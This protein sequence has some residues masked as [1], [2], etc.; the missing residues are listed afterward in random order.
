MENRYRNMSKLGVRNIEGYN[1]RIKEAVKKGEVLMRKIQTGFDAETGKPVYE[2]QPL[3]LTELP[4]IV[5]VVDEFA[6]LMLVAGK[7]VE[8]AIQ[9]L[10]QMARAAGIHLIMA[11]Q[12]PSVDVITGVIKA[13]FPTR[14]SFQVTSKIDSRTILGEGGAETLL[15][16]GD[17]LYM[18]AG[19]RITRVH[20]PFVADKEVEEV[21]N[22]LKTQ[23]EPSYL[24]DITEGDLF[25]DGGED[26][27][28]GEACDELYDEAVAIVA[29]EGKASTS[30][31]QRHLQI[32]Y[33]RAA[34]IMEQMEKEGV[35][36][37]AN[38][39]GK[40]EVLV[41]AR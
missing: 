36:S 39:V 32:G 18:A 12:R 28:G 10:A 3:D 31:I 24:E 1:I 23:G 14:I 8:N 17:M 16:M 26:G 40:R 7:D 21:V 38:R 35:V 34:R 13:N 11:T 33:N 20:G 9:R 41:G 27:E 37:P 5:V 4:Y 29:R 2:E 25:A 15:G 22:H 30:F 6:D 19:G